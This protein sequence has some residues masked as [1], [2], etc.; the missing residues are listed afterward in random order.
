MNFELDEAERVELSWEGQATLRAARA[1]WLNSLYADFAAGRFDRLAKYMQWPR[2]VTI[3]A[4]PTPRRVPVSPPVVSSP[5]PP[6]RNQRIYDVITNT[7][8]PQAQRQ[9]PWSTRSAADL[10]MR[11]P[12]PGDPDFQPS[13]A[14][15][16]HEHYEAMRRKRA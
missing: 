6:P 10:G 12:Q 13:S 8:R 3:T 15:Q 9:E 2:G 7:W 4:N 11:F 1:M 16:L 5:P 14:W